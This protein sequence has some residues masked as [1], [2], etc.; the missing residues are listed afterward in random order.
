MGEAMPPEKLSQPVT[1][2]LDVTPLSRDEASAVRGSYSCA[3][4]RDTVLL[5]PRPWRMVLR[6]R[7]VARLVRL[8]LIGCVAAALIWFGIAVPQFAQNVPGGRWVG[9]VVSLLF[10]PEVMLLIGAALALALPLLAWGDRVVFDTAKGRMT[11]GW[12]KDRPLKDV[13]AV[14]LVAGEVHRWPAGEG[15]TYQSYQLNLALDDPQ[16]PRFNLSDHSDLAWT[17]EAG[18]Q[19]AEFLCVPL[20]DQL[21]A[22]GAGT[23]AGKPERPVVMAVGLIV[24]GCLC[25]AFGV[26]QGVQVNA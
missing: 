21:P 6:S 23:A 9:F 18:R 19:L 3:D 26:A 17:R 7:G 16:H 8:V 15:P 2:P 12:W 14:Q 5:R 4:F 10:R 24:F 13:L 1:I 11:Y 22:E 25:T 20:V